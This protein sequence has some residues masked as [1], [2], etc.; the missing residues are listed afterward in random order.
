MT[1]TVS[2]LTF[3]HPTLTRI[4]GTPTNTSIK[5]L[6]K[7]VYT[8]AHTMPSMHGGGLHGH[9][10]LI[11]PNAAYTAIAGVQFQ[12]PTHPGPAPQ[13]ATGAN[14]AAH[15]ETTCLYKT[16]LKELATAIT[17]TEEIKKQILATVDCIYLATLDDDVFGFANISID[18]MLIHLRNTYANITRA[19]L[20]CNHISIV[21]IW[22][23]EAP[24]KI[25]WECLHEIQLLSMAGND[26]LSDSAIKDLTFT[27]FENTGVFTTACNTWRIRPIANQ[28]LDDFRAHFTSKNKE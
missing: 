5:L 8:N 3:L 10:G 12:L 9:L 23:P 22:T 16:T 17:V 28:T 26:P 20:E 11:M 18:A 13:H 6:T 1:T 25:L 21:T 2:P 14:M 15:A 4:I 7:E 19:E 27:M 24:I